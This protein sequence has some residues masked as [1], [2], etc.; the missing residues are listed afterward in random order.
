MSS[1]TRIVLF[2]L[3]CL[4]IFGQV[5]YQEIPLPP[6]LVAGQ[7]SPSVGSDGSLWMF[8]YNPGASG[9]GSLYRSVNGAMPTF[10]KSINGYTSTTTDVATS[11]LV[12]S[13]S[14][15]PSPQ[16]KD[17]LMGYIDMSIGKL[18]ILQFANGTLRTYCSTYTVDGGKGVVPQYVSRGPFANYDGSYS[19][20]STTITKSGTGA[21]ATYTLSSTLFE[22]GAVNTANAVCDLKTI[23]TVSGNEI[24][25]A[26]KQPGGK[27]YLVNQ[28]TLP[29]MAQSWQTRV[30]L[31]GT[32]GSYTDIVS[33]DSSQFP[34][35]RCCYF[36]QSWG[37]A[38]A[39]AAYFGAD[40]KSHAV[41]YVNG[42]ATEIFNSGIAGQL[43]VDI[44]VNEFRK[45]VA[46]FGGSNRTVNAADKLVAV[47]VT[48]D[49][50]QSSL[51]GSYDSFL[52]AVLGYAHG[53]GASTLDDNGNIFFNAFN[54]YDKKSHLFKA[55]VPGIT[56]TPVPVVDK[57]EATVTAMIAGDTTTMTWVTRNATTVSILGLGPDGG[58]GY[59]PVSGSMPISPKQTWTYILTAI[60]PNGSAHA[61]VTVVV[62]E[63]PVAAPFIS[64]NGIRNA[65]SFVSSLSPGS[66]GSIFGQNLASTSASASAPYPTS[67]SGAQVLVN[68]SPAPVAFASTG[69]INFLMPF[70]T[71][72]GNA[73]V[74]V[75][76][77]GVTS[78]SSTV[79]VGATSPGVFQYTINGVT[80]GIATD[81]NNQ[82]VTTDNSYIR[83][84]YGTLWVTGLGK[85]DP[86]C[87]PSSVEV[88]STV[89]CNALAQISLT[90]DSVL[91]TIQ[92]AGITGYPGEYQVNFMV[93][94]DSSQVPF[95][96]KTVLGK[97]IAGDAQISFNFIMSQQ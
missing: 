16:G 80:F 39:V 70:N 31:L 34:A 55:T 37:T 40:S 20:A 90:V 2:L 41:G 81:Q 78:N 48:S 83:G 44:W 24:V 77:D 3:C 91:A 36:S 45:N 1:L 11:N 60:G 59:V 61:S 76:R 52:N 97:L 86:V 7:G 79:A 75:V 6:E 35:A 12:I 65:A 5:V 33:K 10:V 88:P 71:A 72:L 58:L 13:H 89:A 95:A 47:N 28:V 23:V 14:A 62:N 56:E 9:T 63:P 68:G 32:D 57:F 29:A 53:R 82:L 73:T 30:G 69:Q 43:S 92:Y 66:F 49:T 38:N 67:L 51:V 94:L 15:V 25:Q 50:H 93:P 27:K 18:Q 64:P 21:T 74:Q 26:V 85:L 46:I 96:A 42:V 87:S 22:L 8:L 17:N 54:V 19:L 84:Q 4:P